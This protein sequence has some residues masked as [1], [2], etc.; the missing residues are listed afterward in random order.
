MRWP[1]VVQLVIFALSLAS[2]GVLLRFARVLPN[3]VCSDD[4]YFYAQIAYEL[5]T[6][7]RSTFDGIHTTSGYHLV[8]PLLLAALS[9]ALAVVTADKSIHLF[10]YLAASMYLTFWTAHRRFTTAVGR[11]AAVA[12]VLVG[13]SLTEMVLA[14]PL[15]LAI[16]DRAA[17]RAA[18]GRRAS[19]ALLVAALPLVRIDLVVVPLVVAMWLAPRDAR[20]AAAVGFAAVLGALVQ[21]GAMEVAFGHFVSVSATLKFAAPTLPRAFALAMENAF[22]SRGNVS[23][24]VTIAVLGALPWLRRAARPPAGTG[25]VVAA[26]LS[27]LLLHFFVMRLREWY[28]LPPELGLAQAGTDLLGS[29]RF[30]QASVE[31][32]RRTSYLL[33]AS[34]HSQMRS[35]SARR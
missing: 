18:F 25:L 9:R 23:R 8:W 34:H 19:D 3:F 31:P 28:W 16:L 33:A 27:F 2:A 24:L 7:G 1:V 10:A 15:L 17:T 6:T 14:A 20:R 30:L 11:V 5:G 21:L 35:T 29:I 13:F 32:H 12:F 4:G 26:S 22:G